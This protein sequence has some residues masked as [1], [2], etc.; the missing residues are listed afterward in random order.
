MCVYVGVGVLVGQDECNCMFTSVFFL[1]H[2]QIH[3][4]ACV[5]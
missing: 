3:V 4:S 5:W 1:V 2:V